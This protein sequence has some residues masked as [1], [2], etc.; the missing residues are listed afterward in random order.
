MSRA[1]RKRK[2]EGAGPIMQKNKKIN[3][4]GGTILSTN[5]KTL[6]G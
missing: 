5:S 3:N 2:M 6:H 1:A 4:E